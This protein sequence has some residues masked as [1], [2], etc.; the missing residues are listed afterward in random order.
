[1]AATKYRERHGFAEHSPRSSTRMAWDSAPWRRKSGQPRHTRG[2]TVGVIDHL[3]QPESLLRVRPPPRQT[4]R[5][6][7]GTGPPAHG[8]PRMARS[9]LPKRSRSS[10]PCRSLDILSVHLHRLSI[11]TEGPQVALRPG[12]LAVTCRPTSPSAV[13]MASAPGR[14][15]A[16]RQGHPVAADKKPYSQRAAPAGADPRA[17]R[18]AVPPGASG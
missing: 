12:T 2:Q 7:R 4:R 6:P 3:G 18:Q 17:P 9:L 13:A 5:A 8:S 10:A 16:H 15:P 1:M 14:T 11:V